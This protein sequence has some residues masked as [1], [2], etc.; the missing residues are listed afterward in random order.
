VAAIMNDS[1][2]SK[3]FCQNLSHALLKKRFPPNDVV[4]MV[5]AFQENVAPLESTI[6]INQLI[7]LHVTVF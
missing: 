1:V 2:L 5:K 3:T 4:M 7:N 6:E